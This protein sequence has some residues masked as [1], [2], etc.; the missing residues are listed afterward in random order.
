M[1]ST[2]LSTFPTQ[3]LFK[4]LKKSESSLC[5][6]TPVNSAKINFR[7]KSKLRHPFIKDAFKYTVTPVTGGNW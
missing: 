4:S 7:H 2:S 6:T 5:L 1:I 3:I